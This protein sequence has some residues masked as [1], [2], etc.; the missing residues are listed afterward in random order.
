MERL[1]FDPRGTAAAHQPHAIN[2]GQR[3]LSVS[4]LASLIGQTLD[5]SLPR[6]IRVVGEV[7]GFRERTHW[8]FDLKDSQ[9]VVACAVFASSH[10]KLGF[11]LADGQ[12]VVLTG[13]IDFYAKAGKLS[14]IATKVEPVGAGALDLEFRRL[15]ETLRSKGWLD[16]ER[17]RPLPPFPRRIAV[18]TSRSGAALQD[19]LDTMRRRSPWVSVVLADAR[20]Q[21]EGAAAEIADR[22]ERINATRARLGVD[23]VLITRGG[24]SQQ[25]LWA[26]NDEQLAAAIVASPLPVV[27]AIGH[28]T[29]T[30]LAELVADCRAATPTQAAVMLTPDAAALQEQLDRQQGRLVRAIRRSLSDAGAR[31]RRGENAR[32]L[33]LPGAIADH[34]RRRLESRAGQLLASLEQQQL[35]RRSRLDRLSLRLT[36][37]RP[38][39][40]AARQLAARSARLAAN[41]TRLRDAAAAGVRDRRARLDGAARELQAVGPIAVLRRGYSVTLDNAGRVVRSVEQAPPGATL[42]TRL[43]DGSVRSVVGGVADRSRAPGRARPR[44]ARIEREQPGLFPEHNAEHGP[45]GPALDEGGER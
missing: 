40:R 16:A 38:P 33:R 1:P 32:P 42:E 24:G 3:P 10:R 29:D 43:A 35:R 28:E 8:Y 27:A 23:A 25:D 9:S 15:V 2:A 39:D 34:P 6:T 36:R 45:E 17:K 13:R 41:L 21:G 11:D 5:A 14:F 37:L 26:F 7:A 4:A 44:R 20:V 19:V 18:I 30:T 31:L 12:Q 22:L